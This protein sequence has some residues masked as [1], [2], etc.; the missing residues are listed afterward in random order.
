MES[1]TA[2]EHHRAAAHAVH[3]R[4]A[5]SA[6]RAACLAGGLCRTR[7][8]RLLV[9]PGLHDSGSAHWQTW[10]QALHRDSVRVVQDD[11][12][13]PDLARWSARIGETMAAA[14]DGP[15][16]VA[17]HSFGVLAL[18]HHLGQT[19]PAPGRQDGQ[20]VVLGSLLVAPAEP[21]KF[22]LASQLPESA[23]PGVN[24][25]IGSQSDPWMRIDSAHQWARR[26]GAH[27]LNLGD[28]GHINVASG[29]GPLPIAR[30]WLIAM[31]QRHVRQARLPATAYE[32][33]D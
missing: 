12:H 30:R 13:T 11:C 32:E 10:L 16:L 21:A 27:F 17:A 25:V 33:I 3:A 22:G 28:A 4:T 2:N 1:Q 31:S 26:W 8:P 19:P 6:R 9:V 5:G 24:L 18:A 29:H 7:P 14:G 23:L 20:A 15:W